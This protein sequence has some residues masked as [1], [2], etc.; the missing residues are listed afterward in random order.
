VTDQ[1]VAL[2][3][4]ASSGIGQAVAARLLECGWQVVGV[5]RRRPVLPAPGCRWIE[6]DLSDPGACA[7][8]AELSGPLDG[9]V[10]AAGV[11]FTAPLGRLDHDHG[12]LMWRL[13]VD[14]PT[15][16]LD[17]L[18]DRLSE[19]ARVVLIGSRTGSGV[20]GKS[21]YAATKAALTGLARSWAI[22]LAPRR[23]TVNV[24]APGPT[25]TGMLADPTRSATPPRL[26][27]LGR[28]VEPAEVAG[29]TAFL[30]GAEGG[31]I[32]GQQLVVCGGASL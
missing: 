30:L 31:S 14:V 6:A 16:L 12:E 3:T 10:H 7:R 22:E 29:L 25:A 5:S 15:R 26:P 21:Q 24:V 8:V 28:F 23:I 32:T 2:V 13:H 20:A 17:A 27:A 1:P 18:V 11:Q 4:G 19:G 9:V